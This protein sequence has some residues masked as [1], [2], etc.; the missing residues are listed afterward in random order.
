M[1]SPTQNLVQ[2]VWT[3]VDLWIP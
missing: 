2:C 3:K 1:H